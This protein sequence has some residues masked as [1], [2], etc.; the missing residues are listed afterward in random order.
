MRVSPNIP[1]EVVAEPIEWEPLGR[2]H[3]C[4]DY[5][6]CPTPI[7]MRDR[8][9]VYVSSRDE[10][11]RSHI[12]FVDLD[13]DDPTKVIGTKKNILALGPSGSF[14][15]C[16]QIPSCAVHM[17]THIELWYSG[18]VAP[19]G[20]VAYQNAIGV[21]VGDGESFVRKHDGPVMDRTALE[22]YMAVT[23]CIIG[24]RMWYISGQRWIEVGGKSEPI[25]VVREA[26]WMG[27]WER[28]GE[29]VIRQ[30]SPT[31]CYSRPWVYQHK[32]MWRMLFSYRDVTDYRDGENAYRI[33]EAAMIGGEWKRLPDP[34]V[35]RREWDRTMQ[36]YAAVFKANG[37]LYMLWNGAT[38]G[39]HGFG[40]AVAR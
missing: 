22:P 10:K 40:L 37:K 29:E 33:G 30:T 11:N 34:L 15:H 1:Q 32:A 36:A 12:G 23:P 35:R 24:D 21:A 8:V 27:Y 39:K 31:D 26:K 13:L 28:K 38:F 16:G 2:I 18:W 9:R 5:S 7:V 17:T 3:S 4:D 6:Q 25:Y 19:S 14:D 20:D